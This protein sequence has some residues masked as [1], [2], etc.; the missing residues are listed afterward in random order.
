LTAAG[1]APAK[2]GTCT[3][4]DP[5]LCYKACGPETKKYIGYKA[6]TCTNGA[7][8][9]DSG[10][11][12]PASANYAC[13][14]IPA[15]LDSTCPAAAPQASEP[16]EVATCVVCNFGGTD[17]L[18][19]GKYKTSS[20]E[21]KEGFCVCPEAGSSGSR[22]WSCASTTAWPCPAGQGC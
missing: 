22:S 11:T 10:C 21:E 13:Y 16:C 7:Y 1:M 8:V 14:K 18:T 6:E 19:G 9:E 5:Q 3:D 17:G 20:G 2:N 4:A 15:K 12:F